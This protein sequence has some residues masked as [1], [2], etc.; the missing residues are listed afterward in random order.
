ML[1]LLHTIS[2]Q[3]QKDIEL[4]K[5][6]KKELELTYS[7]VIFTVLGYEEFCLHHFL[8]IKQQVIFLQILMDCDVFETNGQ[9]ISKLPLLFEI[10]K[11]CCSEKTED[12]PANM[13]EI[14]KALKSIFESGKSIIMKEETGPILPQRQS[15][16]NEESY[17]QVCSDEM[18]PTGVS[19]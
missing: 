6:K 15:G 4:L 14:I 16:N 12:R 11:K 3:A 18:P 13:N 7:S 10:A 17:S 5:W 2:R 9:L 8:T 1:N 19:L